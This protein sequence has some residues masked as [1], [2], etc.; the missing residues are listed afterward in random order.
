[1]EDYKNHFGNLLVLLGVVSEEQNMKILAF[2]GDHPGLSY[3]EIAAHMGFIS[4]DSLV[5]YNYLEETDLLYEQGDYFSTLEEQRNNK[6]HHLYT[7]LKIIHDKDEFKAISIN[8]SRQGMKFLCTH[9]FSI[10]SQIS[11]FPEK[12]KIANSLV[13]TILWNFEVNESDII[14]YG[15]SF[16]KHL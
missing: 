13:L 3:G 6:R 7:D 2:Y 8:I 11:I 12:K 4:K 15:G 16:S 9:D 1:M 5:K 10:S 14:I